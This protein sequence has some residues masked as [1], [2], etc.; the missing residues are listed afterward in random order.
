VLFQPAWPIQTVAMTEGNLNR[1]LAKDEYYGATAADLEAMG[2]ADKAKAA[3][4]QRAIFPHRGTATLYA[5]RLVLGSWD[6]NGDVTLYPRE[7]SAITNEFT[8]LYG[9]FLGGGLKKAG[10]PVILRRTSG[11]EAYLLLN[12]RW[13]SERTDNQRWY[14]LLTDWLASANSPRTGR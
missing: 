6:D 3:I 12:H 2:L 10:A 9:R 11:E 5:D 1:L 13:F 14:R 8:D 4:N 7:V